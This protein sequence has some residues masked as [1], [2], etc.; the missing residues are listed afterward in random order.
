[1]ETYH[2]RLWEVLDDELSLF[3][4]I[5]EKMNGMKDL[6][7]IILEVLIISIYSFGASYK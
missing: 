4:I 7:M 3:I 2:L 1:M 6:W 5:T